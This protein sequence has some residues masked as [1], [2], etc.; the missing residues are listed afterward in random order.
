M[1]NFDRIQ[2]IMS[3]QQEALERLDKRV[4]YFQKKRDERDMNPHKYAALAK[5]KV[6]KERK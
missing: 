6:D 2:K 5:A 3:T 4:N 1:G